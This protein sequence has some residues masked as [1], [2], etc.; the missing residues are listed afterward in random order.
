MVLTDEC[1]VDC[2]ATLMRCRGSDFAV[3][4]E[5]DLGD[6]ELCGRHDDVEESMVKYGCVGKS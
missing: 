6:Y 1:G 5:G 2:F 4:R 3:I